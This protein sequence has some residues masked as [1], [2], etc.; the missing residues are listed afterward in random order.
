[1]DANS[2]PEL[3]QAFLA[4]VGVTRTDFYRFF[5]HDLRKLMEVVGGQGEFAPRQRA[6][7]SRALAYVVQGRDVVP[8]SDPLL[9]HVDDYVVVLVARDELFPDEPPLISAE[10]L[11]EALSGEQ[12]EQLVKAIG[13]VLESSESFPAEALREPLQCVL[14]VVQH[15]LGQPRELLRLV[16]KFFPEFGLAMVVAALR[17]D[18]ED[19]V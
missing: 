12:R 5:R 15:R 6:L 18:E 9:G 14:D 7:A 1:M 17:G 2:Y 11:M 3:E 13:L 16:K 10:A 4:D 19:D 8:D